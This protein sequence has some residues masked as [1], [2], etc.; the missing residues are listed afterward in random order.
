MKA[1]C[2][3]FTTVALLVLLA[4]VAGCLKLPA[5]PEAKAKPVTAI[6]IGVDQSTPNASTRRCAEVTARAREVL[7]Q[8][9]LRRLDVLVLGSGGT[10]SGSEP[11]T[12]VPWRSW[13]PDGPLYEHPDKADAAR[14][15]WIG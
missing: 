15:E 2:T 5:L 6:V 8:P 1:R 12:L 7:G 11:V 4:L 9:G 13:L 3:S 14:E 10:A